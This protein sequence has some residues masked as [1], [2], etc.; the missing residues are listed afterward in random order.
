MALPTHQASETKYLYV[1]HVF[2][3]SLFENL[4][5]FCWDLIVEIQPVL[6]EKV[7]LTIEKSHNNRTFANLTL[8]DYAGSEHM[9]EYVYW[10]T[11][12][13][14]EIVHWGLAGR[15]PVRSFGKTSWNLKKNHT[16][17]QVWKFSPKQVS[18]LS[19]QTEGSTFQNYSK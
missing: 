9:S 15:A 1:L 19:N 17:M 14:N 18:A 12:Y 7:T 8:K 5:L 6:L 16:H 3:E 13:K 11:L 10:V 4:K 2:F